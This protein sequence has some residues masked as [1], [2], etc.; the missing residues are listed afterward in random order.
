M[1]RTGRAALLWFLAWYAV[2]QLAPALV[3]DRWRTIAPANECHRWPA[4]RRK[5]A[6][7]PNRPLVL[8]LGSSRA[9]W[10]FQAGALDGM[11]GPDGRP[12]RVFNFGIPAT[13]PIHEWLYLRDMLAEGIRPRLL[14]VEFL[15][16]L[17]CAPE[18]GV[19]SEEG[20]TGYPWL[21][22]R[23]F[24]RLRP[25]LARPGR[26]GREWLQARIA[27]WFAFRQQILGEVQHL[28]VGTVLPY[29]YPPVD[30]WGWRVMLPLPFP[31]SERAR[32]LELAHDGFASG[33][34]HF[35]MG[36]GPNKALHDLLDLCCRERIAV[37][38]V[39]M[40]ESSEFRSWY[41]AEAK[42]ATRGLLDELSREFGAAV[43]DANRWLADEDFEDGHHVLARG[44]WVFT[45]RLSQEIWQ[46]LARPAGASGKQG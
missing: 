41:S 26:R 34:G 19:L 24:L 32:L 5:L 17:L 36:T 42:A 3:K 2:A 43:I 14:L 16:P 11:P 7:E 38:L 30:E 46:L 10:A 35:R 37:A 23:R 40:P 13:G 8:M 29:D 21:S 28:A 20:T 33:L 12:L 44:A 15:P 1:C 18:R 45:S 22:V 9:C 4:L 27:P 39:L 25:Y 6:E 31:A